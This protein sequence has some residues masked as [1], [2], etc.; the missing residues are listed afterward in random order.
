MSVYR[1]GRL[2]SVC[3]GAA[4]R[5]CLIFYS[6]HTMNDKSLIAF[7]SMKVMGYRSRSDLSKVEEQKRVTLI[8]R[9]EFDIQSKSRDY[10]MMIIF[11]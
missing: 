7:S 2:G 8:A 9:I 5:I 10:F 6:N 1:A 4:S 11:G 3:G